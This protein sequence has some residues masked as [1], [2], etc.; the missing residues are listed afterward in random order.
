MLKVEDRFMIKDSH[1]RGMTINE[2]G[3]RLQSPRASAVRSGSAPARR[4]VADWQGA[5]PA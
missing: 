4:Q 2:I 5:V 3:L 1:R